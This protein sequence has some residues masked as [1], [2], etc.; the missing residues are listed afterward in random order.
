MRVGSPTQLAQMSS[1]Q[2]NQGQTGVQSNQLNQNSQA[3][4]N[5]NKISADE[6]DKVDSEK[7]TNEK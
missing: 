1:G 2:M 4:K 3:S 6:F 7:A 5:E